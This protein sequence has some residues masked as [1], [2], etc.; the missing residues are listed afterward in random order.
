MKLVIARIISLLPW[1]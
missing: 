1:D